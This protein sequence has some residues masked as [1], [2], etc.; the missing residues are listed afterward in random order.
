M[1]SRSHPSCGIQA[2]PASGS[3]TGLGLALPPAHTTQ[4]GFRVPGLCGQQ[5]QRTTQSEIS[6]LSGS[7]RAV[8]KSER[9]VQS[10]PSGCVALQ[11]LGCVA[12]QG[13]GCMALQGLGCAA[14]QELG[15]EAGAAALLSLTG[16]ACFLG[17]R[18]DGSWQGT[19]LNLF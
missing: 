14:L 2:T 9:P 3:R 12:L 5:D 7:N 18:V 16:R 1:Y 11:E 13:L 4:E 10:Q 6:S 8:L 19:H 17:F 15:W